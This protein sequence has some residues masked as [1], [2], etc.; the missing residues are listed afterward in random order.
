MIDN[1]N[2]FVIKNGVGN[3][4]PFH[5]HIKPLHILFRFQDGTLT[6]NKLLHLLPVWQLQKI[7]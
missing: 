6:S 4:L 7:L 3:N 1:G 2:L 5:L